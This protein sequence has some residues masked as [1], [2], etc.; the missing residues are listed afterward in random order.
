MKGLKITYNVVTKEEK[1]EEIELAEEEPKENLI[2]C[3]D[4]EKMTLEKRK[5]KPNGIEILEQ[6]DFKKLQDEIT[7]VKK[8]IELIKQKLSI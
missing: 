4:L 3:L 2:T 6:I 8:E 7:Q 5:T 1:R